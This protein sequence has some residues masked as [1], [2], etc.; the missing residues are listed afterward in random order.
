MPTERSCTSLEEVREEIDKLD[1]AIVP[2]LASRLAF[3]QQAVRFKSSD[4]DI[5]APARVGKVIHNVRRL[6]RECGTSETAVERVYRAL[7]D[8][9]IDLEL[10]DRGRMRKD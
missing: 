8:A 1:R 3:A 2:L 7:V 4:D 6:A 10:A 9:T 5:R